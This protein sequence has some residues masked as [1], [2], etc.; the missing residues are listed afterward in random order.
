MRRLAA[1]AALALAGCQS[2]GAFSQ[3]TTL[4]AG[5]VRV[6]VV[7]Q[8]DAFKVSDERIEAMDFA[9]TGDIGLSE[10]TEL[11]LLLSVSTLE[12][13]L[14]Q[15]FVQTEHFALAGILGAGAFTAYESDTSALYVPAQLVLGVRPVHDV[16]F[17]AGPSAWG[18]MGLSSSTRG[19]G[20]D[21]GSF[22]LLGGG[23]AGIGFESPALTFCPQVTVMTPLGSSATGTVTQVSFGFG[24]Q[25]R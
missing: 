21:R 14:K 1:L 20:F 18:A 11:D 10:G 4:P 17:F 13:R 16:V 7:S 24:T 12:A 5:T 15:S 2:F 22:G 25:L 19:A 6:G 8:Y 3:P 9:L 23:V